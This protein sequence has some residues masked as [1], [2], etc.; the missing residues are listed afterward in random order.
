LEVAPFLRATLRRW[1]LVLLVVVLGAGV[2]FLLTRNT[3]DT[4]DGTVVLT[5]PA[6]QAST[7]GS[8]AQYVENF[9]TS[10]TTAGVVKQVSSDTKV[11][12]SDLTDGLLASQVNNSSYIQVTYNATT[13]SQAKAVVVSAAKR[14]SAYLARSVTN[15]AIKAHDAAVAGVTAAQKSLT[16]AQKAMDAFTAK[17]GPLDPTDAL[18]SA[19]SSIN[20]LSVSRLQAIANEKNTKGFDSAISA[21]RKQVT[22][23]GPVV[24]QYKSV[25][26][27]L[28]QAQS[29]YSDAQSKRASTSQALAVAEAPVLLD[30]PTADIVKAKTVIIKS[31]AIAAGV[32]L[33]L[34][35]G[36]AMLLAALRRNKEPRR[37]RRRRRSRSGSASADA[38]AATTSEASSGTDTEESAAAVDSSTGGH[39]APVRTTPDPD[40]EKVR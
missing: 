36:L 22:A 14:T 18:Q 27:N 2:A 9:Q 8:N 24:R 1:W 12:T 20:Q 6:V 4:Y 34:G 25:S 33:V 19:Q 17:Y 40:F 28:S 23:L 16:A 15:D 21:A 29:A 38:A 32:G 13:P 39:R 3:K 37:S 26:Q 31:V 11:S 35:V 7:T 30:T 5:V 10:L